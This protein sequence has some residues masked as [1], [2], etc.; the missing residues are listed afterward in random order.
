MIREL[1]WNGGQGNS[2]SFYLQIKKESGND[3]GILIRELGWNGVQG[4]SRC[5]SY[6]SR[7][8]QE[9]VK[10]FRFANWV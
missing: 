2:G 7:K 1:G 6:K 3:Q 4:N 9:V 5:F 8:S 10:E